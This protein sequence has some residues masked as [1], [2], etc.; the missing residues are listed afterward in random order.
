MATGY[1][2]ANGAIVGV[3]PGHGRDKVI[4]TVQ[5]DGVTQYDVKTKVSQSDALTDQFYSTCMRMYHFPPPPS[6]ASSCPPPRLHPNHGL[7][8]NQMQNSK[9]PLSIIEA[10][11]TWSPPSALVG[12][13]PPLPPPAPS[14]P[15]ALRTRGPPSR[16]WPTTST[17]PPLPL[18]SPPSYHA[19]P[20]HHLHP[21]HKQIAQLLS[22]VT[23]GVNSQCA[24]QQKF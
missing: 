2:L 7:W 20:H 5:G 22:C 8:V 10:P 16:R 1:C 13:P 11:S 21:P 3:Q 23:L 4:V 24:V 12:A 9:H 14:S 15:G 17:S 18:Q 19:T 6:L